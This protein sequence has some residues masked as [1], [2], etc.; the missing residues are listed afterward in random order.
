MVCADGSLLSKGVGAAA[1]LLEDGEVTDT[2]KYHLGLSEHH[3]VFEAELVGLI[4][5]MWMVIQRRE[6][7]N[8]KIASDSQAALK[9]LQ[10]V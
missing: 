7:G 9:A 8:V 4:L 3:T 1:V 6:T 5:V 10:Q 2:Q